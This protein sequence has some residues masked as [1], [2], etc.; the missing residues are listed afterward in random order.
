LEVAAK[1]YGVSLDVAHNA[2]ADAVAAGR[3]AQ[4]IARKYAAKLP[5]DVVALHNSQIQWSLD[6]DASYEKFRRGSAPD[7]TVQRGW[8][9]KL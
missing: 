8:P 2:T 5:D 7:F 4:A 1:T 9:L 6:Q 3:V